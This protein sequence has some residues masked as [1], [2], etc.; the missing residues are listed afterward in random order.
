MSD[1]RRAR[2]SRCVREMLRELDPEPERE[3]LIDTPLRVAKAWEEL[4]AGYS[5]D[6][7]KILSARFESGSYDQMITLGPIEFTSICEHHLLPFPGVAWVAYIPR[8]KVVGISKLARLVECFARRLQIQERMTR[9]IADALQ[10]HL[11][12]L[13]AAVAVSATHGCMKARGIR[14]AATMTTT[15]LTGV[16]REDAAARG[17]FLAAVGKGRS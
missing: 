7:G 12:P 15:A 10:R 4:L 2:V 1:E 11:S 3:G 6:P 17:E 14:K 8:E 13:G 9:E 5:Q 16:F